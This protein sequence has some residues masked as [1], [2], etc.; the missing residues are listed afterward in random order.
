MVC[1]VEK[2]SSG[3]KRRRQAIGRVFP[4]TPFHFQ[5]DWSRKLELYSVSQSNLQRPPWLHAASL[6][7]LQSSLL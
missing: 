3:R 6:C 5:G 4:R 7:G 1:K 2:V